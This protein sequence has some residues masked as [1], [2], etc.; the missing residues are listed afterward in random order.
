[1]DNGANKIEKCAY[2]FILL[3]VGLVI[4]AKIGSASVLY[5]KNISPSPIQDPL[6]YRNLALNTLSGNG[7]SISQTP[8]Y[9]KD[10]F[11]TPLYPLFLAATFLI[12]SSG[13]LAIFLQQLMIIAAAGLIFKILRRLQPESSKI[14]PLSASLFLIADPRLWFWS[15][16]TMTE[17]LFIFLTTLM[18]FFMLDIKNF[19]IKHVVSSAA[20]FGAALLTRPS[21]LLWVPGLALFFL[22]LKK[23]IK[24]KAIM[25]LT[26]S[27]VVILVI[28]PWFWRNYQLVGKPILSSAQMNNYIQAFGGGRNNPAW[29]CAGSIEDTKGRSG[30]VFF[31]WTS[32]GFAEAEKTFKDLRSRVSVFSFLKKNINGS[33]NFWSASDYG[34]GVGILH[35]AIYGSGKPMSSA[36]KSFAEASYRI[37]SVFLIIIMVLSAVGLI[38]LYKKRELAVAGLLAG[39]IFFS[40]FINYGLA[41]GRL[42]LILLPLLFLLAGLGAGFIKQIYSK[43]RLS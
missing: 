30:C 28:S 4:I 23:P 25:F 21:G 26:F 9:F 18:L 22:F 41:A 34:D 37:Y 20:F 10:L 36:W 39:V 1:M 12:N 38:F 31:G 11:R 24:F 29:Q 32:A 8:P 27:A 40:I 5:I 2:Y 6:E 14:I 33:Y 19:R 16:E 3:L 7:F 35:N 17:T 15:L 43:P 42:N 13:H